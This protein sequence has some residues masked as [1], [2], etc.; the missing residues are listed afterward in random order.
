MRYGIRELSELAGVSART[1]RYYDEIGLLK[2]LYVSEA[3]YRFYGEQEVERL[4]QILFYRE[5]GFCLK[6]IREI[7]EGEN[8]NVEQALKEHLAE[9][10][11]RREHIDALIRTVRQ[12]ILSKKGEYE[13]SDKERFEALKEAAIKENETRYGA[14][15]RAKYGESCVESSNQKLKNMSEEEWEQFK[16]LEEQILE[17]LKS[18]VT[19]NISFK[20]EK[21]KEL[22]LLH[23]K[24]L[25]MTWNRYSAEAHRGVASMYTA[26]ERFRQY[27]DS[28]VPGCAE[29]LKQAIEYWTLLFTGQE[30]AELRIP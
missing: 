14:E 26:D 28:E 24:W 9:L 4:Q 29:F 22:V 2:P 10:E 30:C 23:K 6:Q 7:L 21:A 25:C 3:G 16:A 18:H 13:M 12:T 20:S 8:F 19:S 15:I 5:R 1:L 27:Y 11:A 17:Q